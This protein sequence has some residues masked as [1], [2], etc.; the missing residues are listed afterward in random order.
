MQTKTVIEVI[1]P[2]DVVSVDLYGTS[3]PEIVIKRDCYSSEL[4]LQFPDF[5]SM[6]RVIEGLHNLTCQSKESHKRWE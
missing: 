6:V 2:Q 1:P 5:E 4:R 3:G